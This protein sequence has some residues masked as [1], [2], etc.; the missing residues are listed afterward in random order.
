MKLLSQDDL[1]ARI[2]GCWLGKN[3]GG[4]LGAPYEGYVAVHNLTFYDPVPTEAVPNDDLELQAMYAAALVRQAVQVN[5]AW[6]NGRLLTAARDAADTG[7]ETVLEKWAEEVACG[8]SSLIH[9][10]NPSL[11][12]LGGGILTDE[13]IFQQILRHT[14][15]RTMPSFASGLVIRPAALGNQA[16]LYGMV[17]IGR[18]TRSSGGA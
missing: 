7:V 1:R 2:T 17:A 16:G 4:T 15:A 13:D 3:I 9:G 12:V 8:L 14:I 5:P 10:F 11:I 18:N 6:S